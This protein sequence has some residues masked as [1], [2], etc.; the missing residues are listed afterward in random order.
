MSTP[1]G[2]RPKR[3]HPVVSRIIT[4]LAGLL[5]L[6]ALITP[7][8]ISRLPAG[9]FWPVAFVRIPL[10]GILGVAILL[11]LPARP[12][13]VVAT[14]LGATLGVLTVVKIINMGFF[15]ALARQF[16]PVLDW[17]LL[18]DGFSFLT[19]SIGR[20]G[21]IGVAIAAGLLVVA[22]P[23]L[24]TLAV[25][26]MAGFADR[27]RTGARWTALVCSVAW[28]SL[29]LLGTGFI[30]G[31]FVASDTAAALAYSTALTVPQG[32]KDRQAFASEAKVD[33]F[34][35]T[36]ADEMLTGLRGKDVL[37]AFI[38]SYG[39]S[40][41]EDPKY[42]AQIDATLGAGTK[43]LA[44]AGY[45]ARSG[46]LTSSTAG[47]GSWLA[48]STFQS[49]LWINNEQ[50][51][52]T[53]VSS[54]RLTLTSA[55]KRAGSRT[56]AVEP[57]L[58]YAWPEGEF[59]GYDA[60]YGSQALGYR[61]P[62]FS[63]AT[64]PDQFT[65]AA[66]ERL[67]HSKPKHGPLMAEMTFVSSHTPW[68]PIPEIVDWQDI[69]DGSIYGPMV[70]DAETPAELW[71]DPDRVRG[72]YRKSIEYSLNSLISYVQ[73]Y[74]DENLV[75]VFLGDHQ[76]APII[77]GE[78][79]SRDVPITIVAHDKA[80]LDKVA[81]WGWTDGLKPAPQAPVWR[82]DAFRDKFLSTFSGKVPVA[83]AHAVG[84]R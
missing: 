82:M 18:D 67:E 74:G 34:R 69:G 5:V 36:P 15:A 76:P 64:M 75:L 10:E 48:H 22:L 43:A 29:A 53:L 45:A 24:I 2:D 3:G 49:G 28:V 4:V 27:H 83:K 58:T 8:N 7:D 38:E 70:K 12:R 9:S 41:V 17:G 16:N 51:Y 47:G 1:A 52:R 39:R 65:L 55:F 84:R 68:A 77:T 19:D 56:V 30:P 25:R 81:A 35:D 42:A 50:R 61:G 63:W 26:R 14:I 11:V 60:I 73:T 62:S 44:A 23:V 46:Y 72:E 80:V 31:V 21:A 54:D 6:L 57:G 20:R 79:A 71:K 40:A 59:Y 78:D 37:F 32:V 13:R 33:A 66:F